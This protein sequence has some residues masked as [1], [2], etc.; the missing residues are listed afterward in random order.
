MRSC[1]F[2]GRNEASKYLDAVWGVRRA[3][4]TLAKLAVTGGGPIFRRAGRVPLYSTD[5]LDKWVASKLSSAMRSTSDA[6]SPN[7]STGDGRE[8]P[9]LAGEKEDADE[10]AWKNPIARENRRLA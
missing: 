3:P 9:K 5:D 6:C 10:D 2:L 4:S 7:G 1:R 8:Q